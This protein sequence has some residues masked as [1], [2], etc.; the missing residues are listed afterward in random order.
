MFIKSICGATFMFCLNC[1]YL[2]ILCIFQFVMSPTVSVLKL[3]I[4]LLN[5][6]VS[7][8][9]LVNVFSNFNS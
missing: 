2:S 9:L 8:L 3:L 4:T 6:I 5:G 7:F 1:T